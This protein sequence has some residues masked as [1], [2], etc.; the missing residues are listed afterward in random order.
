M[1]AAATWL[2]ATARPLARASEAKPKTTEGKPM[3][4]RGSEFRARKVVRGERVRVI[5][6][7]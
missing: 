3:L 4:K 5:R 7:T 1:P 6:F 2:E